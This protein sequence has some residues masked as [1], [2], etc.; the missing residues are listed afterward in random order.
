MQQS[1]GPPVSRFGLFELVRRSGELRHNGLKVKLQEQPFQVLAALVKR[2]GEVVTREELR[3]LLWPADTFVDFE[4]SLNSIVKKLRDA[5]GDTATNPRFIE[6]LPR[7]GYRFLA[8]VH[9]GSSEQ[10][11]SGSSAPE[12]EPTPPSAAMHRR[13][14]LRVA[15]IGLLLAAGFGVY[16]LSRRDSAPVAE[17]WK[18]RPLTSMD[19][20]EWHPSLSPDGSLLAFSAVQ[21]RSLNLFVMPLNGGDPIR[22]THSPAD[23]FVPRWSPDGRYLAY[24]SDRGEAKSVYLIP[25]QG[26]EPREL[27]ATGVPFMA[28]YVDSHQTLGAQP[29]SPDGQELL[30]SRL[31]PSGE[32][33]LWKVQVTTGE[34]VQ[35]TEPPPAAK[36]L[37]ASW[38]FDG[39]WIV[40]VRRQERPASLWLLPSAGGEPR[41]LLSDQYENSHP[42]FSTDGARLV[43]GSNRSGPRNIWEIELAS[44]RLRRVT[45]GPGQ[46]N[47]ANTG[48][49]G[50]LVF[51]QW[52]QQQDIHLLRVASRRDER[53][54]FH[55]HRNY[56]PRLSPD[57]KKMAYQ[58]S[59]TGNFEIWQFDL[60]SG[61]ERR[62]TDHPAADHGPD[63]SPDGS[64]I[65]FL[66]DRREEPHV[67][68]MTVANGA[69]HRLTR[70]GL[71]LEEGLARQV[72]H[73]PRWSPDGEKIGYVSPSGGEPALWVI[74]RTG[75]DPRP[76]VAGV[77]DFAW[78]RDSRHI[79]Y[80]PAGAAVQELRARDLD[81]GREITLFRGPHRELAAAPDG[82]A[83]TF[84][85]GA[86]M[87]QMD[88]YLLRLSTP[89]D[90]TGLPRALGKPQALTDGHDVWHPHNGSL[91]ADG[92]LI[93]YTRDTDQADIYMI[94]DYR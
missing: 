81:T 6:T 43:F 28:R 44:R 36:D 45:T 88:L 41:V 51:H 63:W 15:L 38:S 26:G 94:E 33:A 21:S 89:D 53:L 49:N 55:T 4:Q 42:A 66:S 71:P 39:K 84:G 30:F 47:G 69:L 11:Q 65:V 60:E 91:S 35:L 5:L 73:G 70:Q 64:Q 79:L 12:I 20:P 9:T 76:V 22:V 13:P 87:Q 32:I 31:Q 7:R 59:R 29:W 19:G 74:G 3:D 72:P 57:R 56:F 23:D 78:Y 8:P 34:E 90:S 93:V 48:R 82:T 27:A 37:Q 24:L 18:I 17:P 58:S 50:R 61:A 54:T 68:V 52:R 2:P 67:W 46:D 83:V 77:L 40:F 1:P 80:T 92:K 10:A 62:L 16:S 75:G 14:W 85:Q 86:S 25:P